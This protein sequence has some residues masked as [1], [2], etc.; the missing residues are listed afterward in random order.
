MAIQF[1]CNYCKSLLGISDSQAGAAV[2]CPRCGRSQK[3]PGRSSRPVAGDSL[4]DL[5]LQQALTTLSDLNSAIAAQ[6]DMATRTSTAEPGAVPVLLI[7]GMRNNRQGPARRYSMSAAALCLVTFAFGLLAGAFNPFISDQRQQNPPLAADQGN[8]AATVPQPPVDKIS[9]PQRQQPDRTI[10]GHV[11]FIRNGEQPDAGALV[12]LL[13]LKN[14]TQLRFSAAALH[15]GPADPAWL[16]TAAALHQLHADFCQADAAGAFQLRS[17]A[18]LPVTLLI[19][20]RHSVRPAGVDITDDFR[21]SAEQWFD[22][23]SGLAGR[24]SVLRQDV[25]KNSS[26]PLSVVLPEAVP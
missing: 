23:V 21:E 7:D 4:Q 14:S 13:P 22:S 24:L 1:R 25:P 18:D 10:S 3:V 12:I 19:I 11:R 8:V 17:T 5:Q 15:A 2:D 20:S 26:E 16:A 9:E 6:P